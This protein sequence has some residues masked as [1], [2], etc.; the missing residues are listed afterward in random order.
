M[1]VVVRWIIYHAL[2]AGVQTNSCTQR[3][4]LEDAVEYNDALRVWGNV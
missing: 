4:E 2:L 1:R 3:K